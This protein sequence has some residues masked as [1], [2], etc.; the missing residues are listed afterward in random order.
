MVDSAIR[1]KARKIIT[2]NVPAPPKEIRSDGP[3]AAQFTK[4]TG[5]TQV[6]LGE[7]WASFENLTSCN[8]FTGWFSRTLGSDRS[9]GFFEM[10]DELKK[11]GREIAWVDARSGAKPKIGDIYRAKTFHV[12]VSMDCAAQWET[13][14]GGQGGAQSKADIVKRRS[15]E[16]N[17]ENVRGWIDIDLYFAA[18]NQ[19]KLLPALLNGWWKIEDGANTDYWWFG[20]AQENKNL[21]FKKLQRVAEAP[22]NLA[23]GPATPLET[24]NFV[25]GSDGK[26]TTSWKG[27]P[28]GEK[29]G[30]SLGTGDKVMSGMRGGIPLTATKLEG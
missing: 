3:T 24:G 9:L 2:D 29:F 23:R 30:Q 8:A 17:A 1:A 4:I 15:R 21:Y 5:L 10:E 20:T 18:M 14:E 12:G 13:A 16:Y 28:T 7:S 19:S 25:L 6:Q 11:M 22:T 27:K 26:V